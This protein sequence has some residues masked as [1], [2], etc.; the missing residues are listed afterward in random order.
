MYMPT[1]DRF[2]ANSGHLE[3]SSHAAAAGLLQLHAGGTDV[4]IRVTQLLVRASLI[5]ISKCT[6]R[7]VVI[8]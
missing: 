4:V 7:N 6:M 5:R 1:G 2:A 8:L 3:P